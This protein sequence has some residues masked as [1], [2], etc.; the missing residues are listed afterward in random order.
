MP[1]LTQETAVRPWPWRGWRIGALVLGSVLLA[2]GPVLAQRISCTLAPQVDG[3]YLGPCTGFDEGRGT[4]GIRPESPLAIGVAAMEVPVDIRWTGTLQIPR[5]PSLSIEIESAPYEPLPALVMKSQVAWLLIEDPMVDAAELSFWFR[6]D[7]DAPPTVQDLEILERTEAILRDE[8]VWDRSANRRC[9]S[10]A[11]TWTLYCALRDATV[12]VTGEFHDRQPALTIMR[13]VI[14][15]VFREMSFEQ[16][17]VDYN[18]YDD[19]ILVEM[20][21]L[22]GSAMNRVRRDL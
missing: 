8:S 19:A 10:A 15:D 14:Q 9:G 21:R 16:P 17:L 1:A 2:P 6:F 3:S 11:T 7:E 12:Q 22:L 4:M 13:A 20:H 18:T 5:W